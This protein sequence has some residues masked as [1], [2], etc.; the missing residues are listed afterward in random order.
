MTAELRVL[1]TFAHEARE[2]VVRLLEGLLERA[3]AGEFA[4]IAAAYVMADKITTDSSFSD[5]ECLP[6][7]IGAAYMLLHRL[8]T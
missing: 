6:A 3:R 4:S 2:D 8:A 1:P 5:T 7:Q